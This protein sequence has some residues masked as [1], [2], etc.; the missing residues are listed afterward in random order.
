[1]TSWPP[2]GL[3]RARS[4]IRNLRT[5]GFRPRPRSSCAGSISSDAGGFFDRVRVPG[6]Q[7]PG[8]GRVRSA[9][10]AALFV[11]VRRVCAVSGGGAARGAGG[12]RG[13]GRGRG[14]SLAVEA[15]GGVAAG[16]GR[17]GGRRNSRG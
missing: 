13:R 9:A 12:A 2:W 3:G 4:S 8:G 6:H 16:G 15:V 14:D 17:G 11:R 7:Q 10:A 1:M 5:A